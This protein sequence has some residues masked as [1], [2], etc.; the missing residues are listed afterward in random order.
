MK[1]GGRD[2]VLNERMIVSAGEYAET[3]LKVGAVVIPVRIDFVDVLESAAPVS[4]TFNNG[5]LVMTFSGFSGRGLANVLK[6]PFKLGV[7]AGQKVGFTFALSNVSGS[8]LLDLIMMA[9][10]EFDEQ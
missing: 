8:H 4:W 1:I 9:G 2:V 5:K 6:K 3:E 7:I 10:G